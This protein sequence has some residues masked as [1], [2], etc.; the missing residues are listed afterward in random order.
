[1]RVEKINTDDMRKIDLI[2]QELEKHS[3]THV[4]MLP[5]FLKVVESSYSL[6]TYYLA[7]FERKELRGIASFYQKPNLFKKYSLVSILRGFWTKDI[8]TED[9]LLSELKKICLK[10]GLKGP[11]FKDLYSSLSFFNNS[12]Q[13][14]Y[15]A[16]V[17]LP[18]TEEELLEFYSSNLRRKIRKAKKEGLIVKETD[19]L[20]KFYSVWSDNMHDLGTPVIPPSFFNNM[21]K[22]FKEQFSILLIEKEKR[23]IGGAILLKFKDE[24]FNPYISCLRTTFKSYPNNLLYHE[25]LN[26]AIENKFKHFDL[27]RSQPGSG[28]EKFKLQYSAGLKPLYS[29]GTETVVLSSAHVKFATFCWRKLPLSIANY[30]GPKI[31]RYIPFA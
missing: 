19:Q 25:M 21:R 31:R 1:M 2:K 4:F 5:H 26:W 10:N 12:P 3:D 7:C 9:T 18:N 16:V 15:R 6:K 20:D 22:I 8:T 13:I 27:G 24:V 23:C 30:L 28:N 29:Y 11:Y 14:V 17:R